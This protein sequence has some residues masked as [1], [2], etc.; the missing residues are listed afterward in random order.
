MD[1]FEKEWVSSAVDGALDEQAINQLASDEQSQKQWQRYHMIGDAMRD[2]L[3]ES[4]P[5]DLSASI[6]AALESEPEIVAP[7]TSSI[8]EAKKHVSDNVISFGSKVSTTFKQFGQYAIAASVAL[9]A[10]IGVQ[11]YQQES[12]LDSNPLSVVNTVPL[13]GGASPVS[14][15]VEPTTLT[16][17]QQE[18]NDK[19]N[20]Q[21][22]RI[23]AYIQDHMLQQRLNNGAQAQA[24]NEFMPQE[25][26]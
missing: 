5:L 18:Y 6:A 16:L 7:V 12:E 22:R 17:S 21:R 1:K 9:V 24:E 26:Q 20:E 4:V 19:I 10:V 15:Q 23:N 2:D 13:V 3:P 11:N 14:W 25:K 8:N